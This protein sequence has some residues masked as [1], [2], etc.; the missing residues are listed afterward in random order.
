MNMNLGIIQSPF[1]SY[2]AALASPINLHHMAVEPLNSPAVLT[3]APAQ[4]PP[5]SP[6]NGGLQPR[7]WCGSSRAGN[8]ASTQEGSEPEWSWDGPG[9]HGTRSDL[10]AGMPALNSDVRWSGEQ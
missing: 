8:K 2:F 10:Q 6:R 9:L 3:A 7:A 1:M 5:P 4:M